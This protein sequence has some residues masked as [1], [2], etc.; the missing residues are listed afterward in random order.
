MG[1]VLGYYFELHLLVWEKSLCPV[2]RDNSYHGSV[3]VGTKSLA[4]IDE[5]DNLSSDR[6]KR[7]DG[8]DSLVCLSAMLHGG[9]AIFPLQTFSR[10]S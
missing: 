9:G 10:N 6:D 2:I 5:K 1:S 7:K 3:C 4:I 8:V